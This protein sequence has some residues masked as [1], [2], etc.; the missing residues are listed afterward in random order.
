MGPLDPQTDRLVCIQRKESV[1]EIIT[2]LKKGDYWSIL[3]PG[4]SGKTTLL[5]LVGR[6]V[7][8]AY[9][10]YVDFEISHKTEGKFYQ[11]L[12][13]VFLGEI[14]SRQTPVI[15]ID[16]N[17]YDAPYHFLDFLETF[18]PRD[19]T[20]KIVLL[21]DNIDAFPF[22]K[23][24]LLLWRSVYHEKHQYKQLRCYGLIITGSSDLISLTGGPH[25]PFNIAQK[26]Y[27][28]DFSA[29]ESEILIDVPLKFLNI[30]I[31]PGAK[32][33]LISEINGHPQMLQHA[34]HM[35]VEAA[36]ES[37]RVITGKHVETAINNLFHTNVN[38]DILKQHLIRDAEF[39]ALIVEIL[40]G[41]PKQFRPHREQSLTAEGAV[42]R[43]GDYCSI[44]NRVYK[45]FLKRILD[46]N[47]R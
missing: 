10:I 38:L 2:G 1:K 8:D 22:A 42:T 43:Q 6:A 21:L 27:I 12:M 31:Q 5:R 19:E 30:Q 11:W 29:R 33:K 35:M 15:R 44:R 20:K 36:I 4:Q 37:N 13:D 7:P 16:E 17:D 25:S 41:K 39:K 40:K 32:K 46:A 9:C 24:F 18:R 47:G 26:L 45:E 23:S 3:G 34:C 28:E 14:P